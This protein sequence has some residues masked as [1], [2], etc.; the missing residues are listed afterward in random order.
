MSDIIRMTGMNSGLDT[1]SIISAL[2]STKKTN[3]DTAKKA[4]KKLEWTQN[5]WKE[6]N[7]KIYN[8]YNTS[9]EK[10]RFESSFNKKKTSTSNN[11]LSV[12]AS[13]N[14]TIGVQTAR[15]TSLAKAGYVTGGNLEDLH[16]EKITGDM[17]LSELGVAEGT[18]I[19]VTIDGTP[20]EFTVD[21]DTTVDKLVSEL[22]NAGINANFDE[23]NQ[24]LFLSSVSTGVKGDFTLSSSDGNAALAALG[25]TTENGAKRIAATDAKLILNDVEFTSATNTFVINNSTYTVNALCETEDISVTTANDSSGIYDMVV[26]FFDGYNKLMNEMSKLYNADS[27]KGYEPLLD[28]EKEAMTDS[29][30]E[31]WE[32]KIKDSLLCKDS[33]L[34]DVMSTMRDTMLKGVEINGETIY[35]SEFGIE[36]QSYFTADEDERYAYHIDGNSKDSVSAANKD[37]LLSKI[38]SDPDSVTAF[39][40][41][42]SKNLYSAMTDKMES[43]EYRSI[44]KVYNDK[45]MKSDYDDYTKKIAELEQKLSDYEDRYY[46]KFSAMETAMAK[47]NSNQSTLSGLF[48]Q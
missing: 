15:I 2:V 8:F 17:L 32:K 24:R 3:V 46:K 19:G 40:T 48:G 11:A 25:L 35:L 13:D 26:D 1:E 7:S 16:G 6:M 22:K 4:Q 39:F 5:I 27:A 10:M 30:I 42:L 33:T 45:K 12:L 29:Q 28:D 38:A 31:D 47:L 36:T 20:K 37:K 43:T 44:Y 18:T 41:Q 21:V 34:S 23:E 14:S 9:L